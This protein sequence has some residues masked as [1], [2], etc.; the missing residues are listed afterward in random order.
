[1]TLNLSKHGAAMQSAWREVLDPDNPVNW[2][3]FGYEGAT[4]DLK[5]LGTGEEEIDNR[6]NS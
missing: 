1:M 5:L 2:A 6:Q 4:F 3:L